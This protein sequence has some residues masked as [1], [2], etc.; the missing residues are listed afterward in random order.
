VYGLKYNFYLEDGVG[1]K[2]IT[3]DK[4]C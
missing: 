4:D 3:S 2:L 1:E